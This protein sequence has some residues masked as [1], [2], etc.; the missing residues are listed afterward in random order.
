MTKLATSN[1]FDFSTIADQPAAQ[2]LKPFIDH[3]NRSIKDIV[4]VL[5]GGVSF[6]D[7]IA[8]QLVQAELQ[9]GIETKLKVDRPQ[10]L[11][12]I[13]FKVQSTTDALK[14]I[15]TSMNQD[16]QM[17]ITPEFKL[18]STTKYTVTLF[19]LFQ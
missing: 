17:L 1:T 10:L 6:G 11:G 5:Q 15:I 9:H 12:V 19:I 3:Y 2:Q 8:G 4:N 13:P 16:G 18:A 14:S 7:N